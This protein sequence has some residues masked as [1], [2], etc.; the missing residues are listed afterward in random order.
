MSKEKILEIT[1]VKSTSVFRDYVALAKPRLASL[2]IVSSV[3]GYGLA[4]GLA[5][6]QWSQALALIIGG[7]LVTGGS[8][9][10][11]QVIERYSDI[12]MNRTKDR[13]IAA[14]R[15][16]ASQGLV[17]SS[18]ISL[19]GLWTIWNFTNFNAFILALAA[20]VSYAFIYTP[21]KKVTPWAVFV[22]AFPGA[23]PPMLGWIAATGEFGLEPGA[24]FAIQ[25]IWQFPHFWSIAWVLDED[26]SRAGFRLLP[27]KGGK[28]NRSAFMVL[29]YSLFL[30]PVALLPWALEI[31][32]VISAVIGV[33]LSSFFSYMAF[34]FYREQDT[35]SA[36]QLM[37]T[38]FFYLPVLQII[39]VLDRVQI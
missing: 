19:L 29:V 7:F 3:L 28:D 5:A 16:S 8:N 2:V 26:Y 38:T 15:L 27:S 32:G 4:T 35:R 21:L 39:F 22:G 9:G 23:I 17:F 36:K 37:F 12:K 30:I 33:A 20:L 14:G 1:E 24:L 31:T 13:P 11:N 25:F 34:L 18:L 6:W 10:L